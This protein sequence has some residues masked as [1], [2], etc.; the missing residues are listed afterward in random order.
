MYVNPDEVVSAFDA[1]VTGTCYAGESTE[2]TGGIV[3]HMTFD[4]T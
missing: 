1:D 3:N 2:S 4:T